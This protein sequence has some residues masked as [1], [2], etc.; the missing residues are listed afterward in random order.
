LKRAIIALIFTL[1]LTGMLTTQLNVQPAKAQE[2]ATITINADGT[3]TPATA[4]ISI[5]DKTTYSMTD[6]ITNATILIQKNNTVL[7]GAGHTLKGNGTGIGITLYRTTHVTIQN[8]RITGFSNGIMINS[9]SNNIITGN[10]IS[11][12]G[13][14]NV[15]MSAYELAYPSDFN[16]ISGNNITR[17]N[18]NGIE[19]D[20][21]CS[22]NTIFGNNV[23]ANI[24]A[25]I[26]LVSGAD[27]NT[28]NGNT[29]SSDLVNG[30]YLFDHSEN[31]II[32]ENNI[33][34]DY[35]YGIKLDYG[36]NGNIFA[37]N[38]F[39]TS[40]YAAFGFQGSSD[41][42]I[43]HNNFAPG[44]YINNAQVRSDDSSSNIWDNGS[45]SGGNYWSD[46]VI[47]Y[48]YATEIDNSSIWNTPYAVSANEIDHYPLMQTWPMPFT[49]T[50][51]KIITQDMNDKTISDTNVTV[52]YGAGSQTQTTNK[53]ETTFW[54]G[55]YNGTISLNITATS[56]YE[57]WSR[58]I[59]ITPSNTV[60]YV[61]LQEAPQSS[62]FQQLLQ[63]YAWAII[64]VIG[65]GIILV[66]VVYA[67]K[68]R[69]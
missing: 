67:K 16:V 52:R 61:T 12:N 62:A 32:S 46:Y 4:P 35:W 1:A 49:S 7:D 54:L 42:R 26:Y 11:S 18:G 43:Y 2:E 27:G 37:E 22:N 29:V 56:A 28:I 10:D 60:F 24:G 19:L 51:L 45:D 50:V 59:T 64:T 53:G 34:N 25:G 13:L 47:Q 6:N 9:S 33:T 15:W 69:T 63:Q 57:K 66:A 41:N 40:N 23:S 8:M 36:S 39:A 30:I 14:E 17:S 68:R 3:I 38:N 48:P 65:V 44:V 20:Y 55:H 21:F 31:N 5:I 58:N